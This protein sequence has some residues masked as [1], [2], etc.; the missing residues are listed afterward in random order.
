M[1]RTNDMAIL[2]TRNTIRR[3]YGIKGTQEISAADVLAE[4]NNLNRRHEAG[5]LDKFYESLY[6]K[7]E[8]RQ[9]QM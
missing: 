5:T 9:A 7:I 2:A 1:L 3:H 8:C 6:F 4:I